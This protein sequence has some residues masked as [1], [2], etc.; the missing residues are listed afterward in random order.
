MKPEAAKA[1]LKRITDEATGVGS[2]FVE[3]TLQ[4][5]EFY[6]YTELWYITT[7]QLDKI[8][9]KVAISSITIDGGRIMLTAQ[10]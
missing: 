4:P 7:E 6:I 2:S 9:E 5:K 3:A 1:E 10:I 8:R